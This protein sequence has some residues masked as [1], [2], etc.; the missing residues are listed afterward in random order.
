LLDE[1]RREKYAETN[2]AKREKYAETSK[3]KREKYAETS[4]TKRERNT[5]KQTK[6]ERNTLKQTKRETYAETLVRVCLVC[7]F[8]ASKRAQEL[9]KTS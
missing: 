7:T 6:R 2:T 1:T 3:T 9:A 4:K 8:A 5:L